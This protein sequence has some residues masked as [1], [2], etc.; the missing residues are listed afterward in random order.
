MVRLSLAVAAARVHPD[1]LDRFLESL[2]ATGLGPSD[3][4]EIAGSPAS[5]ELTAAL[6]D[7]VAAHDGVRLT[8][9]SP[10]STP[11]QLWGFAIAR[12]QGTHVGILDVRD[13]PA[14]QWVTKWSQAPRDHIVC[15]PVNPGP[16]VESTS[17]AAYLSE[18]GQ[19]LAPLEAEALV[20]LPG[21]NIVFPRHLLPPSDV[22]ERDGFWKTFHIDGMRR[23]DGRLPLAV[24]NG[25]VVIVQRRYRL[26]SYLRRRYLH[27]RCYGGRRLKE[28][29]APSRLLCLGLAPAIPWIRTIR[30]VRRFRGKR[31][32][33]GRLADGFG[34]LV[35]GEIAWSLGEFLGYA[36]GEGDACSRLW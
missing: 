32:P 34:A 18:Y 35:L 10:C 30:V 8:L 36:R 31:T 9:H 2:A 1:E 28:P 22:L 26:T 19:F 6:R 17:W 20:E 4:V 33:V 27:G 13:R 5:E 12:A 25:M 15:G 21:N 3:R 23:R 24:E 11:M 7:R 29:G 14:E 16:L